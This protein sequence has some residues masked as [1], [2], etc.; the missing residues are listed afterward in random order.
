MWKNRYDNE[1]L[2]DGMQT[3]KQRRKARWF[4]QK[5]IANALRISL[6]RYRQRE[7]GKGK[8]H[9]M[10]INKIMEYI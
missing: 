9:T 7:N 2:F 8:L 5:S 6:Y 10:T 1:P 3:V 4:T